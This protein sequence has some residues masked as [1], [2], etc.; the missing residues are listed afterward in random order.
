MLI[1]ALVLGTLVFAKVFFLS[2]GAEEC[3]GLDLGPHAGIRAICLHALG[4]VE[5]ATAIAD[6]LRTALQAGGQVHPEFTNVIPAGDLAAYL[7]WTGNPE[8]ALSWI[9]RAY[10]LSPSGIDPRVL[11]SGLF[12]DLLGNAAMR[13][14]VAE[15]R[16][17]IWARVQREEAEAGTGLLGRRNR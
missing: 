13:R 14:E 16:D 17:R 3:L 7:A 11:E 2:G 4:R 10:A 15:I 5:Q 12:E 6:S 8:R 9:Y 1:G